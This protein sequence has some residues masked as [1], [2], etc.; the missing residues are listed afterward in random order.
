[1]KKIVKSTLWLLATV[2]L[3]YGMQAPEEDRQPISASKHFQP[4]SQDNLEDIAHAHDLKLAVNTI[5][6]AYN[7]P[8]E[9]IEFLQYDL[10]EMQCLPH[11]Q[12]LA[13]NMDLSKTDQEKTT[14]KNILEKYVKPCGNEWMSFES[15]PELKSAAEQYTHA[16]F[17]PGEELMDLAART[18]RLHQETVD[19]IHSDFQRVKRGT[20][21]FS[22]FVGMTFKK[23]EN[24]NL[25]KETTHE[26]I[27][28]IFLGLSETSKELQCQRGP[29]FLRLIASTPSLKEVWN[30]HKA[31]YWHQTL[32]L[33]L[34]Q[35]NKS[36]SEKLESAADLIFGFPEEGKK[37]FKMLMRR[38]V[39]E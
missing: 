12:V 30:M 22:D 29:Y 4:L 7:N 16:I 32:N 13:R 34:E 25:E 5:S 9:R 19:T 1:M 17:N 3:A 33:F 18:H 2:H 10:R 23:I 14:V 6:M 27:E 26:I 20:L 21:K 38:H 11:L 37:Y 36:L 31:Q 35:E 39:Q 28:Q 8:E 15:T 24:A